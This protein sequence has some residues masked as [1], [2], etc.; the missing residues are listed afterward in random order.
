MSKGLLQNYPNAP[1]VFK[2]TLFVDFLG[3]PQKHSE[4][5][6]KKGLIEHMK[7]FILELGKDFIFMDQEYNLNVGASTFKADLLFFQKKVAIFI[8]LF[9]HTFLRNKNTF[10][11]CYQSWAHTA[12]HSVFYHHFISI[13]T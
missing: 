12:T 9:L 13:R 4:A 8:E 11:F 7:Q 3:L 2:D 10:V 6:L 1:V 5:K